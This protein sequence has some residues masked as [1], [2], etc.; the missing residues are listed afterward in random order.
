MG[1]SNSQILEGSQIA[2][3][4]ATALDEI[5]K[6]IDSAT[7]LVSQIEA[8]SAEQLTQVHDISQGLNQVEQFTQQSSHAATSVV[9]AS[10]ELAGIIQRLE[11]CCQR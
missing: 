2:N 8:T 3:Q 11:T 9:A 5:T 1:S 10:Q 7:E 6:L 4:T